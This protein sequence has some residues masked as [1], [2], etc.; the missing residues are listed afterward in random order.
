M[1][2]LYTT[3]GTCSKQIE[4][5]VDETTNEII[6]VHFIGGCPG[7][8]FGVSTLVKGH[9][10]DDII[11]KLEGIPCGNKGTSCPDQLAQALKAIQSN[12]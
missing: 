2:Y 11:K 12:N 9:N 10:V 5:E 1:K 3:H 4:I 7:N 8:T 6:N